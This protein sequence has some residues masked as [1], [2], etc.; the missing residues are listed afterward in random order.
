MRHLR[1]LRN[2]V[3]LFILCTVVIA[4][5]KDRFAYS[6]HRG[7]EGTVTM[8]H[9]SLDEWL[10]LKDRL[11]SGRYLW[12]R[13]DGREYVIRDEDTL[14]A[15]DEQFKPHRALYRE[16]EK[17][18]AQM[19]PIERRIDRLEDEYDRLS[20]AQDDG[21]LTPDQKARLREL[22]RLLKQAELELRVF[23]DRERELERREEEVDRHIDAAVRAAVEKAVRTG[24]ADRFRH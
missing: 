14:D 12:A 3:L 15:L 2:V 4:G 8:M 5:A 17:L 7:R 20:N 22:Y 16:I 19:E 9:G 18:N 21:E 1:H 10:R 13:L 24:K 6:Y 23:E 11:G